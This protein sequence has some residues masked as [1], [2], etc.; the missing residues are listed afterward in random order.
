MALTLRAGTP[1][2]AAACGRICYEAFRNIN[3]Q[4]NFPPELPSAEMATGFM[5]MLFARPD[6]YS[7]VAEDDGRIIGSNFLW[8]DSQHIAGVGPITVDPAAQNKA[9]G[10][11]MME[12]ILERS[13][14]KGFAGV[15]LVQSAFHGRS[16]SLY[17]KLGF[18]VREPLVSMHGKP[19]A[20]E[21]P[22]VRVRTA[23]MGDLPACNELCRRVHGHDRAGELT[24]AIGAG[25]AS[26]VDRGHRITGYSTSISYFGHTVGETNGDVKALISAVPEIAHPGVLVPTRNAD[27]FRWCLAG[28]GGVVGGLRVIQPLTLMSLGL[29]NEPR[30]AF[31]PSILY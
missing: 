7:V 21:I 2:D 31:L 22:G 6:I 1:D 11:R 28:A 13:R 30:G 24:H 5:G 3:A 29:Y 16:M 15:R 19:P 27:L 17:A 12:R 25:Q 20:V 23:A 10:R 14:E 8:E 9:A 26:V 18:E 4:H